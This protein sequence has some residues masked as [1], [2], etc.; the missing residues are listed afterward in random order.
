MVLS[1]LYRLVRGLLGVLIVVCRGDR[2]KDAELLVLRHEN[3]VLR[4]HVARVRYNAAD[5]VWLACLAQ[6]GPASPLGRDLLRHSGNCAGLA[7][8]VGGAPMELPRSAPTRP[9]THRSAD[10]DADRASG[11]R[12]SSVGPPPHPG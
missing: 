11:Q 3:A 8:S 2:S 7:S 4:R 5:R 12:E 9:Q 10:Q 1:L 6:L